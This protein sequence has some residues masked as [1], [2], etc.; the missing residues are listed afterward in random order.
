[1]RKTGFVARN[2]Y[3]SSLTYQLNM[4]HVFCQ[5]ANIVTVKDDFT[6][7]LIPILLDVVVFYHN[8]H[9]IHLGEELVKVLDLV[10]H[11]LLLSKERIEGLQRTSQ[12][13]LLNVKHLEGGTLTDIINVLLV[14]ET[15][16]THSSVICDVMGFHNLVDALEHEHGLVVIGFHRLVNHFGQLGIVAHEEPGIDRDAVAAYAGA[17][18]QDVHAGVHVADADDFIHIHI[19]VAADAA[20]LVGKGDVHGTVGVL[21]HLGHLGRAD[22]GHHNLALAEGGVVALHLLAYLAAVGTDGAV[23]V[24]QLIDHVAGDDALGGMHEIDVVDAL[25]LAFPLIA[26]L[27]RNLL[28]DGAHELVDGAG[29]DG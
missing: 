5:R 22:V 23:V 26:A 27:S 29:A 12:V 3:K 8:Y 17:G 4:V 13:T 19:V 10:L 6:F 7:Q 9:H 28:D 21:H 11:N 15:I 25:D 18:L 1:M 14:G 20:K 2:Q 16:E 24:E